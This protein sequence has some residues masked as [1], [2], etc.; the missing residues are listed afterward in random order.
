MSRVPSRRAPFSVTTTESPICTTPRPLTGNSGLTS[1]TIP[2]SSTDI[3]TLSD[4][5]STREIPQATEMEDQPARL[6]SLRHESLV[7]D[8]RD[9]V[10]TFAGTTA[11]T[12]A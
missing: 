3:G 5:S 9:I 6:L 10:D 11:A 12:N 2:G 8:A 1:K 4:R 7:V